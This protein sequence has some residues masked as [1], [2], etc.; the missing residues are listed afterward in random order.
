MI[1]QPAQLENESPANFASIRRVLLPLHSQEIF[2]QLLTMYRQHALRMEL[3][4]L[5]GETPVPQSHDDPFAVIL[6][7]V[8][9]DFKF[10][11]QR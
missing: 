9:A 1:R 7:D 4:S 11:R 2:D 5:D 8:G 6:L 3:H 10:Y